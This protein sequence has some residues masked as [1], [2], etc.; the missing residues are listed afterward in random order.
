MDNLPID[1]V[2]VPFVHVGDAGGAGGPHHVVLHRGGG[3]V[4]VGV[5]VVHCCHTERIIVIIDFR[6]KM[7]IFFFNI[8][9]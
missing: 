9:F 5:R 1:G 3:G 4:V 2:F 8:C 7:C 6:A